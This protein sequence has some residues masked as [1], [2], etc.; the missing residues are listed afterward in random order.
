M[1]L[2]QFLRA[3]PFAVQTDRRV[4]TTKG[5]TTKLEDDEGIMYGS[6][7][8]SLCTFQEGN[9]R[10]TSAA[11]FS[12]VRCMQDGKVVVGPNI[13]WLQQI[14]GVTV[15][16]EFLPFKASDEENLEWTGQWRNTLQSPSHHICF[17][18]M[19]IKTNGSWQLAM[20]EVNVLINST[21]GIENC[22]QLQGTPY[23][24]VEHTTLRPPLEMKNC[25]FCDEIV[26][27]NT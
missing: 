9:S 27:I 2:G 11:T 20:K 12:F 26:S 24:S 13:S 14:D 25:L 18:N 19:N 8:L 3:Y 10:I 15:V 23:T 6:P 5:G 4:V 21:A 22:P 1:K 16:G 7:F 17:V